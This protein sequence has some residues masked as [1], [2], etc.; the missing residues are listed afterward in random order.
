MSGPERGLGA[1][2]KKRKEKIQQIVAGV[3]ERTRLRHCCDPC[4]LA[5]AIGLQVRPANVVRAYIAEGILRFPNRAVLSSRGQG[6]YEALARYILVIEGEDS[7]GEAVRVAALELA[8]P[9]QTARACRLAELAKVQP[10]YPLPELENAL[11]ALHGS[12]VMRRNPIGN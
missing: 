10:N 7:G 3:Y 6:I 12:C 1:L 8:L 9:D 11:M 5:E 4:D 2:S